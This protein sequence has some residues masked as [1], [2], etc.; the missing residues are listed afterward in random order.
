[1]M[2][3]ITSEII[4]RSIRD[5]LA[6]QLEKYQLPP[7][8]IPYLLINDLRWRVENQK[9][10]VGLNLL[11]VNEAVRDILMDAHHRI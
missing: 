6:V 8:K 4:D 7:R 9:I 11:Y 5:T 1:M 2:V 10:N 3:D